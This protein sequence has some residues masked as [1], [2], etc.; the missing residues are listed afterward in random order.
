MERKARHGI[1]PGMI[2]DKLNPEWDRDA[3]LERVKGAK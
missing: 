2:A 1:R 3:D